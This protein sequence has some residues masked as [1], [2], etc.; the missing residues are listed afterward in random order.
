MGKIKNQ[1]D[2]DGD[3]EITYLKKSVKDPSRFGFPVE[4]DIASVAETD[5]AIILPQPL[6]VGQTKRF[7][8][9]FHFVVNQNN[10]NVRYHN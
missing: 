5:I 3:F 7:K 9:Y 4:P 1:K 10:L 6:I 8:S 2:E